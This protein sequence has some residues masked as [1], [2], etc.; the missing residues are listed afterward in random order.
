MWWLM[1]ALAAQAAT[2][3]Y[4][5]R[6]ARLRVVTDG[7]LLADDLLALREDFVVRM[8][9]LGLEP[10]VERPSGRVERV[11]V[12]FGRAVS[13]EGVAAGMTLLSM[14]APGAEV[15]LF[16]DVGKGVRPVTVR[17][18]DDRLVFREG[19]RL[20]GFSLPTAE[21]ADLE[22][23]YDITLVEEGRT[24]EPGAA[25]L[26]DA[27]L[28]RLSEEE[29]ALV[30][31]I[32]FVRRPA[33]APGTPLPPVAGMGEPDALFVSQPG[34]SRVEVYD[35]ALEP[36]PRFVGEPEA[37]EPVALLIILHELGHA[38]SFSYLRAVDA[39]TEEV[40]ARWLE[41]RTA[42]DATRD[43]ARREAARDRA[44]SLVSAQHRLIAE[45][46]AEPHPAVDA[47]QAAL[48]DRP[49]PT[50]YG[51]VHPREAFAE[52]FALYHADRAALQRTAPEAVSFFDAGGHV[53]ALAEA[54]AELE[55][56]LRGL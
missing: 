39:G 21:A 19:E 54:V 10:W 45:Q 1:A 22:A 5:T 49:A 35:I 33:P 2:P 25:G 18:E 30:A 55:A 34:R 26:L 48:G 14:E 27:A 51:R 8:R 4:D 43:P 16:S 37:P 32:D 11:H 29:R 28:A 44:A 36:A 46:R 47:L 41:A 6:N 38:L 20:A 53:R 9:G 31:G 50:V 24:W 7:G 3:Y 23:R 40:R 56:S 12:R 13:I 52:C 42:H 17:W 15:D